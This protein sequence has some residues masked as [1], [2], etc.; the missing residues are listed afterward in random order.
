MRGDLIATNPDVVHL[1]GLWKYPSI[2]V[3]SWARRTQKPYIIS[4]RGM[5]EPWAL[6]Q[7]AL[8]KKIARR[9][10][11]DASLVNAACIHATSMM[12]ARSVRSAGFNNPIAVIPNGVT[13][14][15]QLPARLNRPEKIKQALFLS[16]IH[17]KKGLLNLIR[18]WAE[19]KPVGWRLVIVG[20]D[21]ENHLRDVEIEV[22]KYAVED[23]VIFRGEVIGDEKWH[24]YSESDLFVLPSFSENFGI[25]I[26][27]ALG[28]GV[29]VITTQ[30]T[31]WEDITRHESGWWIDV[32][33]EPLISALKE[34]T[35]LPLSELRK[36]GT[37]GREL[38]QEQYSWTRIA[39]QMV[40]VYEW[41]IG[42]RRRP[43][44]V[45]AD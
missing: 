31:P 15:S 39:E 32:G 11:Q 20:P 23:S 35:S 28:C 27:E 30:A 8:R 44:C 5:L 33:L 25:A 10:F 24:V 41:V 13:I 7:S 17:P 1:H 16:R 19:L 4:P 12:E 29:P 34:A 2:A 21:E 45:V 26:A 36:M 42:G 3:L 37:R 14:P 43:D 38:V 9:L 40:E 22:Q 18:A 6:Q